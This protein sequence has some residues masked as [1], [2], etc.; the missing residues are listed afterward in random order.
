MPLATQPMSSPYSARFEG[1]GL[2]LGFALGGFFDG[3]LLHQILQ[4]HH[5]LSGIEAARGDIRLLILTDGRFHLVMY[6][7]AVVGLWLLWRTRGEYALTGADRRLFADLMIGFGA[8]HVLDGVLSHWLLGLHRIRM[9]TDMPLFWDLLWF[10]VFGLLPMVAGWVLRWGGK[11]GGRPSSTLRACVVATLLVAALTASRP[12]AESGPVMVLFRP[13]TSPA[14]A[15]EAIAAVNGR[16]LWSDRSGT[17]LA[18][19]IPGEASPGRL[20][21]DGAVFVSGSLLPAGCFDWL[22]V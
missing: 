20:F 6:G 13:G 7:V 9:D 19:D 21:L 1:A 22:K 2:A 17:A 4:W 18:I 15:M 12:A 5:L 3:I 10:G 16:L 11:D 8:W 14:Q